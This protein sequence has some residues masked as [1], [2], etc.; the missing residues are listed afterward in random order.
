MMIYALLTP[1]APTLLTLCGC[2]FLLHVIPGYNMT[3]PLV[4][5]HVGMRNTPALDC[6]HYCQPGQPEA[7]IWYLYNAM[8]EGR[9]GIRPIPVTG[10]DSNLGMV[11]KPSNSAGSI[12]SR[13]S[14]TASTKARDSSSVRTTAPASQVKKAALKQQQVLGQGQYPCERSTIRL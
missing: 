11:A 1:L 12:K 7:W 5:N 3:A 6:L 8:H 2:R 9:A 10:S 13:F 4:D 14:S